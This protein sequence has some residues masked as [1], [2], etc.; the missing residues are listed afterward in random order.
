MNT[1]WTALPIGGIKA[2]VD[3]GWDSQSK[4]AGIGVVVRDY[5]GQV[6]LSEWQFIPWCA[7][8]EEAEV[9]ACLAGL[10]HLINLQAPHAI[11][12][13]DCL[14]T[15]NTLQSKTKDMSSCW[16]LYS[17]GQELVNIYQSISI[18]KVNRRSNGLAHALAQLGKKGESGVIRDSIPGSLMDLVKDDCRHIWLSRSSAC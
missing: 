7:S 16:S 13:S 3:A 6:L 17:E 4:K 11:M 18:C 15:V 14:R 9:L 12:E 1:R 5:A 2:N 10:K 8:A